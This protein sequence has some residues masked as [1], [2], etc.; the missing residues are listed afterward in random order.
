[1]ST[2]LDTDGKVKQELVEREVI[3][4]LRAE[5]GSLDDDAIEDNGTKYKIVS[6]LNKHEK[7]KIIN[8]DI[9]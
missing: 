3:E 7:D 8:N 1:L 4:R 2:N 9:E 5:R 6:N